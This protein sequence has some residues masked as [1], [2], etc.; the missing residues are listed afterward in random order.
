MDVSLS[1][2][3]REI[4]AR[5]REFT[6]KHLIPYEDEVEETDHI[7]AASAAAIRQAVL[8][9][10]LNAVNH[11]RDVGGQ[12]MTILQQ[13]LVNEEIG[14]ATN[15]LF[16]MVWQP[17]GCL[18][19]GTP[20][21]IEEFL[22]PACK[23]DIMECYSITE[24]G[25]GSDAGSVTTSAVRKGDKFVINGR[26]RFASFSDEADMIVLHALVD[27]DKDK[28]TLFLVDPKRP[29]FHVTGKPKL[30]LRD[31]H[32]HPD[33]EYRDYELDESRLLGNIGQGFELTKEWFVWGRL[34]IG[35]RCVGQAIRATEFAN[36]YAAQRVQF[37]R[38]IRDFQGIEF[39][40]ADMAADI[41]A[42]KSLVY[43]VAAE[44]TAGLPAKVAH[45]RV[46]A[47][48]LFC[49]EMSGRVIDKAVQIMGG[50]GLRRDCPIER[51]YCS[52]RAERIWDG[53]SEV[54][55]MI[56]A[57]QIKKRGLDVY[58]GW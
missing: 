10:R 33:I 38:P 22:I 58:S 40:L 48:K 44:M 4:R 36:D 45:A 7:S 21:Q 9:Y 14:R 53:T 41:M 1:A 2:D 11:E 5:A 19:L 50:N 20:R 13:T 29:G 30:L 56:M 52:T 8:D 16:T 37:G 23:G 39:M 27:G 54:Q 46:S 47:V 57:G 26:K 32:Y 34:G 43:R 31:V 3:D 42:A 18:T 49:S 15:S 6:E 24:P 35:A 28:P 17:A 55:R 12:G 25:A 51:L